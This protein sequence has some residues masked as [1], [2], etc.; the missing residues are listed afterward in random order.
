MSWLGTKSRQR[1]VK[2]D[3][4]IRAD[5]K[6]HFQGSIIHNG[7]DSLA[8]LPQHHPAWGSH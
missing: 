4:G 5:L 3:L 8:L 6:L 1:V 2:A 7:K